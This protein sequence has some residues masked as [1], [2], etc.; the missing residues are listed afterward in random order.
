MIIPVRNIA[1][2]GVISDADA[3]DLGLESITTG[4]NI[5]CEDLHIERAPVARI[6]GPLPNAPRH[7]MSYEDL[8]GATSVVVVAVDGTISGWTTKTQVDLTPSDYVPS[9]SA[10][11][12]TST[13]L[14][15][16]VYINR[17]D[18]VPMYRGKSAIG[19]FST[20]N[21]YDSGNTGASFPSGLR[22]RALRSTAGMLIAINLTADGI[23]IPT[24]VRW[25]TIA[26]DFGLPSADWD[27]GGVLPSGKASQ[28]G[29][30]TLSEMTGSLVDG[31]AL[32]N[33]LVL[34][35]SK[36]SWLM[37]YVGGVEIFDFR[38][39]FDSGVLNTNCVIE[40]DGVHY[41]FGNDD[42]YKHDGTGQKVSIANGRVRKYINKTMVQAESR[43]AF[44]IRNRNLN[45]IMFCYVSN[46]SNC[47]FPYVVGGVEGCNRAAVYNITGDCWYF[48]D[49]PYATSATL[50]P[51]AAQTRWDD[52]TASWASAGGSWSSEDTKN[53]MLI[54]SAAF[55]SMPYRMRSFAPADDASA[56]GAIDAAANGP[57]LIRKESMDLDELKGANPYASLR[58][59]KQISGIDLECT[60]DV[61]AIPIF[62]RVGSSYHPSQ[63]TTWGDPQ[64]FDLEN[65]RIDCNEQG[66]FLGIEL[67]YDDTKVFKLSGYDLDVN[68]LSGK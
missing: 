54:A 59:N 20:L 18:H 46:D 21:T 24:A 33:N 64:T 63:A 53:T 51:S 44:A 28:G 4:I 65:S 31:L 26:T 68:I 15:G 13:V 11:V 22:C 49:L 43:K 7:A 16:V 39:L 45:E 60:L 47:F 1:R 14:Q 67:R 52:E 61:S 10:A 3:R 38:R 58:G 6:A 41:V 48:Y 32:A 19:G 62:V 12:V 27:V 23:N 34:Y 56:S 8:S 37:S 42:I 30:N 5:R 36:E 66:R 50:G 29:Q 2:N 9:A 55:G 25:S 40:F 35:G 17:E 57:V